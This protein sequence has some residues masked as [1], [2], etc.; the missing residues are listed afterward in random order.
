MKDFIINCLKLKQVQQDFSGYF[1]YKHK[2][3]SEGF[4]LNRKQNTSSSG[5]SRI[6]KKHSK[7]LK[8]KRYNKRKT[9]MKKRKLRN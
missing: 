1:M 8:K 5:G 2:S 7:T 3:F 6:S 9:S 4:T